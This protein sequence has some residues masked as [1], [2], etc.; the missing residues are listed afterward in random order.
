MSI[1]PPTD[2]VTEVAH[3]A[4]PRKLHVAMG[5]LAE[6]SRT[7]LRPDDPFSALL[8][9]AA[10]RRSLAGRDE[11]LTISADPRVSRRSAMNPLPALQTGSRQASDATRNFEAF[12]IQSF[13]QTILPKE[14]RGLFGQG[15]AG[16]IWRSMLAEQLGNQIAKAGGLG[17]KKMLDRHWTQQIAQAETAQAPAVRESRA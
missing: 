4:D 2:I 10:T 11:N 14:D 6:L 17:L 15:T 9:E 1:L 16:G 3:A 12:V 13:L 7:E 5:R 8:S